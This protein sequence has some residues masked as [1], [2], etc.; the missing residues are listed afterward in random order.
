AI[1]QGYV[2]ATPMQLAVMAARI[3][4]GKQVKPTLVK[5]TD[6]APLPEFAPMDV[7]E[8]WMDIARQGMYGVVNRPGGTAFGKRITI[9]GFEM[10]GKTG[11]SQVRALS[12]LKG[13]PASLQE[14]HHQHHALFVCYAP[15]DAPRYAM[16]VV[17]EHGKSGSA[18]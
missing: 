7:N 3:A 17:V 13:V 11:T 5:H 8:R 2:L 14:W 10:A 15:F 16:A 6:G 4:S 9:P 1:G 12:K 18:A